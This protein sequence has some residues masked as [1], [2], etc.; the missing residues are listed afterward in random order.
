MLPVVGVTVGN[1][2]GLAGWELCDSQY[3]TDLLSR[4]MLRLCFRT[5]YLSFL[6]ENSVLTVNCHCCDAV[7]IAVQ[8]IL[9]STVEQH[10][11]HVAMVRRHHL[12]TLCCTCRY[13]VQYSSVLLTTGTTL[14]YSLF[15]YAIFSQRENP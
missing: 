14:H 3:C 2:T 15:P 13:T 12:L 6:C 1:P 9:K 7:I 11:F 4:W 8:V 10:H 5:A